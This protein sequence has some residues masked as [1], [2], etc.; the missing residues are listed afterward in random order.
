MCGQR[1]RQSPN[2][3]NRSLWNNA[4]DIRLKYIPRMMAYITY[5]FRTF[6]MAARTF[7]MSSLALLRVSARPDRPD[8]LMLFWFIYTT[9]SC[10]TSRSSP[11]SRYRTISRY[12]KESDF[13][14]WLFNFPLMVCN[15]KTISHRIVF[16]T[17]SNVILFLQL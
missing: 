13:F 15:V 12:F 16:T 7:L 3:S 9:D 10:E 8:I 5:H 6:S 11:T 2:F 14:I 1:F 4:V 17:H